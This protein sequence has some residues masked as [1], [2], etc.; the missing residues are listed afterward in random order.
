MNKSD[1]DNILDKYWEGETSVAEENILK[2]YFASGKID[3]AHAPFA[4]MFGYLKAQAS[5]EYTPSVP[6]RR[7]FPKV[8]VS[9]A[10]VAT[11]VL[12]SLFM[13]KTYTDKHENANSIAQISKGEIQDPEEAKKLT[14]DAL[15]LIAEKFNLSQD[16]V[17]E[18][19]EHV[20]KAFI[21]KQ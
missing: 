19:M 3:E 4:P 11:F 2:T 15:M 8:W 14:E 21:F 7:I 5:I 9:V 17:L 6:V 10:A 16:I 20:D 12:A 18:N 13:L 1:I